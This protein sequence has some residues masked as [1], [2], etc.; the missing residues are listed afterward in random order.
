MTEN[1]QEPKQTGAPSLAVAWVGRGASCCAASLSA[2]FS[3]SSAGRLRRSQ[4][5]KREEAEH[6]RLMAKPIVDTKKAQQAADK[7]IERVD[8]EY[9]NRQDSHT[10]SRTSDEILPDVA[11][12]V[13]G[14]VSHRW[15]FKA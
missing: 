12:I 4:K 6:M 11:S 2:L 14:S 5:P 15:T 7:E 10:D 3:R 13:T 8:R 1:D 9:K